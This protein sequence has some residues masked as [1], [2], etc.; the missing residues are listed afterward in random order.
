MLLCNPVVCSEWVTSTHGATA[1]Q[2]VCQCRLSRNGAQT[3][4][5]FLNSYFRT[6]RTHMILTDEGQFAFNCTRVSVLSFVLLELRQEGSSDTRSFMSFSSS[7]CVGQHQYSIQLTFE[8]LSFQKL[9]GAKAQASTNR[10]TPTAN[11][12]LLQAV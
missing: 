8:R 4:L 10:V 9:S 7:C 12:C 5:C 6:T 1:V 11:A 3:E 2:A